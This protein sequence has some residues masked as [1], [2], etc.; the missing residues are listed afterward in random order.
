MNFR[1]FEISV[2]INGN[3]IGSPSTIIK[4]TSN[5]EKTQVDSISY[6]DD[7]KYFYILDQGKV[8]SS[9]LIIQ[10]NL[11]ENLNLGNEE[12]LKKNKRVKC[13]IYVTDAKKSFNL[14]LNL[15][16][17]QKKKFKIDKKSLISKSVMLGK[18]INIG[19][20]SFIDDNCIIDDYVFIYPN[21][22]IG[23][24]VVI[25][26]NTIIYPGVKIYDNSVINENCI[27]HAGCVIGSDG[28]GFINEQQKNIK[29]PH[30]G[31]V[32]IGKD[33]EIGANTC[34]DR[35]KTHS[36]CTLID[37]GVKIDNLVQIGHNVKIGKNT[38]IAGCTGIAGSSSIGENCLIGGKVAISNHI[39]IAN[40]IKIAG[41][42]G[43][44]KSFL[45]E[46]VEI[47][48]PI[49]FEKKLFQKSYI[50]FKKK[51]AK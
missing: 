19:A 20:F 39:K 48:G 37:D 26:E 7:K 38:V 21:C 8:L 13:I 16:S 1:A 36:D 31:K 49:A 22:F 9:V 35:G 46:G 44:T 40:N 30:L 14:I 32:S 29:I 50:N 11:E 25:K 17:K 12:I 27:I 4:S 5:I 41:N 24:N 2:K 6:L 15:F 43:V 28:F 10:K 18:N 47:Q 42:S 34:I 51:G 23:K 3:L 33:V 45:K